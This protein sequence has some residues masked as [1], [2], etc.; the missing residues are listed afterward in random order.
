MLLAR[1]LVGQSSP[2]VVEMLRP[3]H[4]LELEFLALFLVN[5]LRCPSPSFGLGAGLSQIDARDLQVSLNELLLGLLEFAL[6]IELNECLRKL[7]RVLAGRMSLVPEYFGLYRRLSLLT[8]ENFVLDLLVVKCL[9]KPVDLGLLIESKLIEDFNLFEKL[10]F[11]DL[12][13]A[14]LVYELLSG[15]LVLDMI[16]FLELLYF[17][18]GLF[19]EKL[20]LLLR[21]LEADF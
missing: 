9:D 16:N 20:E 14:V 1:K 4:V 2:Y 13:S 5:N 3:R 19:F 18:Q 8:L 11:F 6:P 21:G 10:V 15:D 12:E 17:F 7:L